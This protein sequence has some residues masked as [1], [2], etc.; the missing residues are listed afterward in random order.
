MVSEG[1]HD[2]K[3]WVKWILTH[4][5]AFSLSFHFEHQDCREFKSVWSRLSSSGVEDILISLVSS[6]NR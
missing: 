6:A 3:E 2:G 1:G 5:S 4:L